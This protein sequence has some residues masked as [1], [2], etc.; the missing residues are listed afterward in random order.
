MIGRTGQ[1]DRPQ[2]VGRDNQPAVGPARLTRMRRTLAPILATTLLLAACG[3]EPEQAEQAPPPPA[4]TTPAATTPAASPEPSGA[5]T[6]ARWVG[7][8]CSPEG[9]TAKTTS[10][11]DLVC[12]KVGSDPGPRWHAGKP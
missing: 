3:S 7:V 5:P 9:A 6:L 10:G 2:C 1:N 11:G 12:R 8:A 4:A